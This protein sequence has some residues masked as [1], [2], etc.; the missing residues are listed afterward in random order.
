[1][2]V[3]TWELNTSTDSPSL[4]YFDQNTKDM[5][6][7]SIS[8]KSESIEINFLNGTSQKTVKK[9]V[10]KGMRERLKDYSSELEEI[11]DDLWFKF[12]LMNMTIPRIRKVMVGY[13]TFSKTSELFINKLDEMFTKIPEDVLVKFIQKGSFDQRKL[14]ALLKIYS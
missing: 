4:S 5:I 10:E 12:L 1:M 13:L 3:N 8:L 2:K 11:P 14:Q 7:I 6:D 9:S